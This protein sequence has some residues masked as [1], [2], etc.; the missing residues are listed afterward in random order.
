MQLGNG[1][2]ESGY[3]G[4][5]NFEWASVRKGPF[6]GTDREYILDLDAWKADFPALADAPFAES[7][8]S[9]Y[10]ACHAEAENDGFQG[11]DYCREIPDSGDHL[12]KKEPELAGHFKKVGTEKVKPLLDSRVNTVKEICRGSKEAVKAIVQGFY[13]KASK[14]KDAAEAAFNKM[15]E[16]GD[17]DEAGTDPAEFKV[18]AAARVDYEKKRAPKLAKFCKNYESIY[19]KRNEKYE[20][21]PQMACAEQRAMREAPPTIWHEIAFPYNEQL[22]TRGLVAT[23]AAKAALDS[24]IVT[25]WEQFTK[26]LAGALAAS[27]DAIQA[28]IAEEIKLQKG[29]EATNADTLAQLELAAADDSDDDD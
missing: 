17:Q 11:R 10:S 16:V 6:P 13:G 29:D 24:A 18:R 23:D 19:S 28:V 14:A 20:P 15:K 3:S 7:R 4:E 1:N 9:I 8:L 2:C 21:P 25:V 5:L 27:D 26:D 12:A 22:H